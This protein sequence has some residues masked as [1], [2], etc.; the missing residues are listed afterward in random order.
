MRRHFSLVQVR[1]EHAGDTGQRPLLRR[2]QRP[3]T[4]KPDVPP[5]H[6]SDRIGDISNEL[7]RRNSALNEALSDA[8]DRVVGIVKNPRAIAQRLPELSEIHPRPLPHPAS[9]G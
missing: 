2:R 8:I 6:E 4:A 5:A 1:R 3:S 9:L 7:N